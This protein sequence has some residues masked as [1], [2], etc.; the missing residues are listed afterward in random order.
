MNGEAASEARFNAAVAGQLGVPVALITGDDVICAE[1]CSWL[2]H[3]ATA[4]VKYAID[5]YTARCV[6]QPTAHERIRTAACQVMRRVDEMP[7]Y[8]L[9]TP[10]ELEM[11]LGDSSM[12]AAAA[13][14]PGVRRAG[15]RSIS[16]SA[17]DAQTAHNVCRIALA[18]AG[19]VV[20]RQRL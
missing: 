15:E 1:T 19:T 20:T 3:V 17:P 4:V 11:V 6:A 9:S 8:Q 7:P 14:I 13:A 2:P 12:A 5:R 10:V 16:Y 18:L